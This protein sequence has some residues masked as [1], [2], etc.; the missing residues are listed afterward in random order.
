MSDLPL[1]DI[2]RVSRQE[3]GRAVAV[4]EVESLA[5][6]LE[7]VDELNLGNHYLFHAIRADFLRRLGRK[8]D[9]AA[10]YDAAISR[11]DNRKE[12]EFLTRLRDSLAGL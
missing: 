4:A 5:A 11:S 12:R 6:A 1:A 9:A 7:L 8:A 2:E 10:A 3:Y